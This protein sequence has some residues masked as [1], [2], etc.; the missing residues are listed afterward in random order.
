MLTRVN[1]KNTFE[2]RFLRMLNDKELNK[3]FVYS[4]HPAHRDRVLDIRS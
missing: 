2:V 3:I 1:A 4:T